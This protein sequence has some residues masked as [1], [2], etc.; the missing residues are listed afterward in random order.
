MDKDQLNQVMQQAKRVQ[1]Q[2]QQ[3]QQELADLRVIGEAGAGMVKI[4]MNGRH[5]VVAVWVDPSLQKEPIE[6]LQD[7]IKA[8]SN[9]AVQKVES[10]NREKVAGL[11]SG[12]GKMPFDLGD[13]GNLFKV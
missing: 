3:A 5:D 1:E 10:A 4:T 9:D 8:A 12:S 11:A 13:L 2:M 6:V 7:L